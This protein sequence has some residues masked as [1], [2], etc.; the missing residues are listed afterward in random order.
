MLLTVTMRS[1]WRHYWLLPKHVVEEQQRLK[2][3]LS[4]TKNALYER[5]NV[6]KAKGIIMKTK[7]LSEDQAYNAMRKLAMNHNKRMGEVAEQIISAAE[8]L[9]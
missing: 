2:T 5:K 1:T 6:E 9:V 3:E 8:V 7:N 4:Q